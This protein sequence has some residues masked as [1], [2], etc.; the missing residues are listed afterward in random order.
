MPEIRFHGRGGQGAVVASRVLAEAAFLGGRY[1]QAF[2]AFGLERR[3]APVMAFTRIQDVPIVNH[4]Q[5]HNPDIVVVL[6]SS[7]LKLLSVSDGLAEEGIILVNSGLQPDELSG[8]EGADI[9]VATVNASA[10][11]AEHSLGSRAQPIVNTAILGAL[12]RATG[13]VSL[14]NVT[15]AIEK[16]V[17]VKKDENIQACRESYERVIQKDPK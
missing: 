9:R 13:I 16:T 1:V 12:A 6:D 15:L 10:I 4:S 11:A 3:G 2:P 14:D 17:S 7:L 8:I 5:I